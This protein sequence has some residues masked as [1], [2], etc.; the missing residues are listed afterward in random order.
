MLRLATL[1]N[2]NVRPLSA[3]KKS[4]GDRLMKR[5]QQLPAVIALML[6]LAL[7]A[8]AGDILGPGAAPP[9][10]PPE[11]VVTGDTETPEAS[12]GDVSNPDV[13]ELD[14]VTEAALSLLQSILSLF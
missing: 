9:P 5:L 6:V 12:T 14:P 2:F 4:L 13:V 11:Y 7:S 10:P 3:F 8:P 1:V